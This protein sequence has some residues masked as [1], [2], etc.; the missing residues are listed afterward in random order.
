MKH[1]DPLALQKAC[2]KN[3]E[4]SKIKAA[5]PEFHVKIERTIFDKKYRTLFVNG[6]IYQKLLEDA[7]VVKGADKYLA[8]SLVVTAVA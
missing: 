3:K 6:R 1:F 5:R 7:A 2:V 4:H 8:C